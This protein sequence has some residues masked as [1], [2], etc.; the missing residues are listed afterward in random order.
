MFELFLVVGVLLGVSLLG[1]LTVAIT[2]RIMVELGLWVL[3]GGLFVGIPT[4]L[5]YHVALNRALAG[6]MRLPPRWWRTPV[7]VHPLLHHKNSDVYNLGLWRALSGFFSVV[8]GEWLR[9]SDCPSRGSIGDGGTET[10]GFFVLST[11][12]ALRSF[13]STLA[14]G[15]GRQPISHTNLPCEY[16]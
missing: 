4:G 11:S 14:H 16:R 2:P 15:S 3:A 8:W 5:W 1:V 13:R 6:R 12:V 10:I 9:L 7:D